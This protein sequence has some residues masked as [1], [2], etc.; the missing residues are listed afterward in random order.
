M[1]LAFAQMKMSACVSENLEL[2]LKQIQKAA[3]SG[4]DLIFF[5]EIQLSPFFVVR[6]ERCEALA[7]GSAQPAGA[8]FAEC[9]QSGRNFGVTQ[10]ISFD[11]WQA[12]RCLLAHQRCR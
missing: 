11:G 3:D 12:L 9:M 8:G 5:P 1:K 2:S 7:V 6:K 10:S 4:A